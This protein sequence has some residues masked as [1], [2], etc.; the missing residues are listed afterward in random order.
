MNT[1]FLFFG[2]LFKWVMLVSQIKWQRDA[3]MVQSLIFL[4]SVIVHQQKLSWFKTNLSMWNGIGTF[5]EFYKEFDYL[6][7]CWKIGSKFGFKST[8]TYQRLQKNR[9]SEE[10]IFIR[11]CRENFA[12]LQYF[13][14]WIWGCLSLYDQLL[15]WNLRVV[16]KKLFKFISISMM[17]TYCYFGYE[18]S[19]KLLII[20]KCS[21]FSFLNVSGMLIS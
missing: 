4:F 21:L 20:A 1:I 14:L 9:I 10:K 12:L 13:S 18:N 15:W 3:V 17:F 2:A 16:N 11:N 7:N 6:K 8:A 5:E 19:N